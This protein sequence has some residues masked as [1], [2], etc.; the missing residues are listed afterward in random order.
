M[1]KLRNFFSL[2]IFVVKVERDLCIVNAYVI[3]T[4]IAFVKPIKQMTCITK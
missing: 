1:E 4:E 3:E 2:C